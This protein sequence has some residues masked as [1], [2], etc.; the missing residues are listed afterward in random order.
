VG[1]VG[2]PGLHFVANVDNRVAASANASVKKKEEI[3]RGSVR[4][5]EAEEFFNDNVV[6]NENNAVFFIRTTF[7]EI[8]AGGD[9]LLVERTEEGLFDMARDGHIIFDSIKTAEDNVEYTYL[10]GGGQ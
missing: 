4:G 8:P 5:F 10:I 9:S 6:V 3:E 1:K 2:H 7:V